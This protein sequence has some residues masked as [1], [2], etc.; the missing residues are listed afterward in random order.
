MALELD[1]SSAFPSG[2]AELV[3][4]RDD[5]G[6]IGGAERQRDLLIGDD[7]VQRAVGVTK[8]EAEA[9]QR[10]GQVDRTTDGVPPSKDQFDVERRMASESC[11]GS[12]LS[13]GCHHEFRR[14]RHR[15]LPSSLA[16]FR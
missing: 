8:P 6:R 14:S 7:A 12:G 5:G 4:S 16:L 2:D 10:E 1:G 13:F 9:L 11:L 3:Q 15:L